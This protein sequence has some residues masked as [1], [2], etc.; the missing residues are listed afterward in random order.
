[1]RFGYYVWISVS[2]QDEFKC[3]RVLTVPTRRFFVYFSDAILR[4]DSGAPAVWS[5]A[6]T[7]YMVASLLR[8]L[9]AADVRVV[10]IACIDLRM[11]GIS[12][13]LLLH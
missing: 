5:I 10:S 2:W 7:E 4:N 12:L 6:I 13:V 11:C 1:M 9:A 3:C 8:F